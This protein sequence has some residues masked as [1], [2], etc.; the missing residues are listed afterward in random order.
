MAYR[1]S[2]F[3]LFLPGLE[4]TWR[5]KSGAVVRPEPF[6][7]SSSIWLSL[8][9]CFFILVLYPLPTCCVGGMQRMDN[10]VLVSSGTPC[11]SQ[12]T[13][14]CSV[15]GDLKRWPAEGNTQCSCCMMEVCTR[16][17]PTAVDSW[18]RTNQVHLQVSFSV[19]FWF[20]VT[21]FGLVHATLICLCVCVRVPNS[22]EIPHG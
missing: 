1:K 22:C 17:A 11:L 20:I 13:V 18:A 8:P 3:S 6:F 21:N 4:V 5:G 2:S 14:M 9:R 16:V 12:G 7:L 19:N 15:A 10:W